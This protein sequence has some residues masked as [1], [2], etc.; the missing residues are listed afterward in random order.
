[1]TTPNVTCL[2]NGNKG[3]IGSIRLNQII[4]ESEEIDT[5][6]ASLLLDYEKPLKSNQS[7][8]DITNRNEACVEYGRILSQAAWILSHETLLGIRKV[9]DSDLSKVQDMDVEGFD[10]ISFNEQITSDEIK[11]LSS[12]V[13]V[14]K[15][16]LEG[17]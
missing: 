8:G 9:V 6:L 16:W 17:I 5:R 2:V 7:K 4:S 15:N 3:R 11:E 13:E 14:L 12:R 10:Q 1:M